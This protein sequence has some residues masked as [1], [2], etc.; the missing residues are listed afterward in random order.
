VVGEG[1]KIFSTVPSIEQPKL[2]KN[3]LYWHGKNP[4][5]CCREWWLLLTVETEV[6]GKSKTTNESYENCMDLPLPS[7]TH[8]IL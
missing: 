4:F 3:L 6:N 7:P 8:P 2:G 5:I 1:K